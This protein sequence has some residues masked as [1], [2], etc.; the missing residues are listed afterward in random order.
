MIALPGGQP[1]KQKDS[2]PPP[3]PPDDPDDPELAGG[4]GGTGSGAGAD[5]AGGT[6]L[7]KPNSCPVCWDGVGVASGGGAGAVGSGCEGAVGWAW[8]VGAGVGSGGGAG[9]SGGGGSGIALTIGG[10]ELCPWAVEGAAAVVPMPVPITPVAR[11]VAVVAEA[12]PQMAASFWAVGPSR[13]APVASPGWRAPLAL[14]AAKRS[15]EV[16]AW[17]VSVEWPSKRPR[18][19]AIPR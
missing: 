8:G 2:L 13:P 5:S 14:K 1:P 9:A 4:G 7:S 15:F 17:A 6:L 10:G 11:Q 19:W 3:P 16:A 18:W 12:A